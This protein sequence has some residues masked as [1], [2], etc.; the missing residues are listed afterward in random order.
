MISIKEIKDFLNSDSSVT[1]SSFEK[2]KEITIKEK[3][4]LEIKKLI[5][6]LRINEMA[7]LFKEYLHYE[8]ERRFK[9]D[10]RTL[11]SALVGNEDE[12]LKIMNDQA[13]QEREL[14]EKLNMTKT[15]NLLSD[16]IPSLSRK[17]K[18]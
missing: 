12:V 9:V 6:D 14:F 7:R 16:S 17:L 3:N 4:I 10:K 5:L 13:H 8:Y 18:K 15:Y 1:Q 11:I 2:L